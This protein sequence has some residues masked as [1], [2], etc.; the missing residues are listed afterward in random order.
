MTVPAGWITIA[1]GKLVS[2]TDAGE[3]PENLDVA[4][5][6]A[7]LDLPHHRSRRRIRRSEAIAAQLARSPTTRRKAAATA[8]SPTTSA[9]PQ[10]IELFNKK[11]GVDYPWEKY[12][13]V[14][15]DDFVAGGMENSSATTNTSDSLRDPEAH[16][17][18]SAPNTTISSRTNSRTSGSAISSPAKTGPTSG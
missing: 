8:S 1:N 7:Q 5:I 12:A 6:P 4:R 14:M 15:V 16:P 3:R 13:Q 2:V 9:R 17:R 18:I 11:I 10:M